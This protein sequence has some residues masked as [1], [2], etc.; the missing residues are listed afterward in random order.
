MDKPV[1]QDSANTGRVNDEP[2]SGA[3]IAR[4]IQNSGKALACQSRRLK[5][6][7]KGCRLIALIGNYHAQ[8]LRLLHN[9]YVVGLQIMREKEQRL[10]VNTQCMPL[11][12]LGAVRTYQPNH[13]S[14]LLR[15]DLHTK[16]LIDTKQ[17]DSAANEE[18]QIG[19]AI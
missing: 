12:P 1:Q 13:E 9:R 5:T 16:R 11:Y 10:V 18:F 15:I 2:L 14:R 4:C 6:M 8:V 7:L 17:K 3:Y 19:Q